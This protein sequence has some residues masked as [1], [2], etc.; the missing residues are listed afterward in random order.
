MNKIQKKLFA[1]TAFV[2]ALVVSG[3]AWAEKIEYLKGVESM[4]CQA[5]LCLYGAT[6]LVATPNECVEPL[7]VYEEKGTE[8]RKK[9][10]LS[11]CPK[12]MAPEVAVTMMN[13]MIDSNK[14]SS[15]TEQDRVTCSAPYLN[16]ILHEE[17]GYISDSMPSDCQ[18]GY[19]VDN[20]LVPPPR[21]V[22]VPEDGGYWAEVEDFASETIDYERAHVKY[23]VLIKIN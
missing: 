3:G 12:K 18:G 11:R 1:T 2:V 4:S 16:F 10:F 5:A 9:E 22:G 8:P 6:K 20:S 13:E 14:N 19:W 15:H 17:G 7:L 23:D 21:Y